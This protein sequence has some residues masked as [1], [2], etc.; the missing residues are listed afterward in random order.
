MQRAL[1]LAAPGVG[2]TGDNPSVGCVIVKD[3]AIVGEAATG[4]GGR[5]HGEEEALIRAGENAR[6]AS[7]YITLEPCAHRSNGA[8]SCSDLLIRAHVA[9]VVIA[10]R[11]PHPMAAGVGIERLRAAG[12]AVE[13]GL[14]EGEARAQNAAFFAKWDKP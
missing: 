11:D 12:T 6:G 3:S 4:D 7:A 5:P 8:M 13:I 9:R 10:T 14:M 1:A 2:R